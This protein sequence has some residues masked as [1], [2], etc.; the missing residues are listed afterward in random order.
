MSDQLEVEL[1]GRPPPRH[2]SNEDAPSWGM[3]LAV[4]VLA[5]LS[6]AVLGAVVIPD[7]RGKPQG[8]VA[9]A[10]PA[11][12]DPDAEIVGAAAEAASAW[13]RFAVSGNLAT[14]ADHFVEDGPQYRKLM[15]EAVGIKASASGGDAYQVVTKGNVVDSGETA[16]VVRADVVWK[17]DGESDQTLDWLVD[18]RKGP[19]QRWQVWTI[20]TAAS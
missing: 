16:A 15:A 20:R 7:L 13:G 3:P 2:R 18:L 11:R 12:P 10:A 17:R 6:L 8:R 5:V 19:N 4:L 14:L 9:R 1:D